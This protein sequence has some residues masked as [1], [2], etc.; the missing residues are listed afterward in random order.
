M[1]RGAEHVQRI[2][3][4][5]DSKGVEY[6]H[7]V[8]PPTPS[9]TD[10]AILEGLTLSSAIKALLVEGEGSKAHYLLCIPGDRKL[11]MIKIREVL[12]ERVVFLKPE[13]ILEE[14]GLVVGGV[15]PIGSLLGVKTIVDV[16]VLENDKVDFCCGLSTDSIIMKAGV[17]ASL[18][19]HN[20]K[21]ITRPA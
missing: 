6:E 20:L 19:E 17:F 12:G 18:E 3:E 21:D 1:D 16:K 11:D 5:L 10:T 15:H 8:H 2:I 14:Y 7:I 13:V 4:Y 9:A